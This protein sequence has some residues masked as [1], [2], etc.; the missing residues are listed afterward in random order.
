[1]SGIEF[2]KQT[3]DGL[4]LFCDCGATT[5][6]ASGEPGDPLPSGDPGTEQGVIRV[7][8]GGGEVA[9]TCHGCS[10]VHWLTFSPR[11]DA[12]EGGGT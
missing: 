2:T 7:P 1:M 3:E 6:L 11:Q 10:S 8:I 12:G 4:E 5:V 9:F